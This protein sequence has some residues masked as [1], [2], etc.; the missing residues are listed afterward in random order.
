MRKKII[1]KFIIVII[2][3]SILLINRCVA[4]WE[5]GI[6][7]YQSG[8]YNEAIRVFKEV[9]KYNP[10]LPEGYFMIGLC[11][12]RTGNIKDALDNF[13]QAL[14]YNSAH[15]GSLFYIGKIYM[16]IKEY[17]NAIKYFSL[18]LQNTN[19]NIEKLDILKLRGGCYIKIKDYEKAIDDFNEVVKNDYN[20]DLSNYL[21][22]LA[23]YNSGKI[24][25]AEKY[26]R[27]AFELN[28]NNRD[29]GI[30]LMNILLELKKYK[31]GNKIGQDLLNKYNNDEEIIELIGDTY[32]GSREYRKAI[33]Y[34]SRLIKLNDKCLLNKAQAHI[35]L[36]EYREAEQILNS[37]L[38]KDFINERIIN[39]LCYVYEK[40]NKLEEALIMYQKAYDITANVKYKESIQRIQ[41]KIKQREL[42]S[43][44]K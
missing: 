12:Y 20:D 37:L 33:Y 42:E 24:V 14:N 41:E 27:I 7:L 43:D 31:E 2:V 32:L 30:L 4:D 11:Y 15:K 22:G 17:K 36:G 10:K 39:L 26:A 28:S 16:E 23:N 8:N 25:Q 35:A 9:V 19:E 1:I 29:Y 38:K 40:S 21:L 5:K 13:Q 44:L 6:E 34:Y 18:A 3:A